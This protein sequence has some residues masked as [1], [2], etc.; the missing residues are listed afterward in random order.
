MLSNAHRAAV[1]AGIAGGLVSVIQATALGQGADGNQASAA[2]MRFPDISATQIVFVYANNL[3]I[4]PRDGGMAV[5]VATAPGAEGFPRFS[6]DGKTIA[7]MGNYDSNRDLYTIPTWGGTPSRVT[8][9]PAGE[10]L[11]D[12]TADGKLVFIG[13]GMAGL[14]RQTQIFTVPSEG[15]LP[16]KLPVPYAGFGTISPD[17]QWLCYA[18]HS[19][20]NRTWKRYRGGMATDLWVFN[21]RN[22]SAKKITDWEGTDT[23]PMWVPGGKSDVVYY[24]ADQGPEHRL[25]IWSYNVADGTRE[26]LTKYTSDDIRWPSIGPGADG[27]GEVIFQLGSELHVFDLGARQDRVVKITIPGDKPQVRTR[28]ADAARNISSAAISSSGKRV[29]IEARG[30]LWSAPAKEGIT[31]N[32]TNTNGV[33]ERDPSWSP[34]NK[35]IAYFS[36]E[37]GDYE[38]WIRGT[39]AKLPEEKK[40]EKK[41]AKKD[42]AKAEDAKKEEAAKEEAK[43]EEAKPVEKREPR[44]LTN[45]GPGFR[46]NPVWSPDSKHILFSD[47]S[48]TLHLIAV[49]SGELKKVDTDPWGNIPDVSWSQDN[50]WIAYTRSSAENPNSAIWV[51]NVKTGEKSQIVSGMFNNSAPAFDRAGDFM[52]FASQRT[53]NNPIYADSDTTFVYTG[54]GNIY[55]A[56]LRGDVKYPWLPKS[57]EEELKKEEKKDDAKKDGE[58]K[59]GE[60][61]DEAAKDEAKKD[62]AKKEEKKDAAADDGVSGTWEGRASGGQIPPDG[63]PFKLNLTLHDDGKVT[64]S[65]ASAMGSGAVTGTYNKDSGVITLSMAVGDD[66]VVTLT[67][68]LKNG[69]ITGSWNAGDQQGSWSARR[70]ASAS[71]GGGGGGGDSKSD[72]KKDEKKDEKKEV[73]IDAEGFESRAWQLPISPGAFG[74]L[75]VTDDNKLIYSRFGAR[76]Q[77]EPPSIKIFDPKDDAREEKTVTAGAGGFQL[78]ADGKK[79]LVMRGSQLTVM[80]AAAGGGTSTTVPTGDMQVSLKPREEWKQIV[81]D[82]WRLQRDFFY[83]PTMHG[84]DW[85]AARDHYLKMVD[86]AST[87]E[88]VNYIISEMISEL[89]IGHAY[90]GAPGDVESQPSAGTGVLG[91]DFELV[92]GPEGNAYKIAKIYEGGPWDAD[93]RNPLRQTGVDVKEGEFLLAVNGV[94]LDTA[95]DPWKI[96]QY[97]ADETVT[98][99]IGKTPSMA[100][101]TRDVM[102]KT[103]GGDGALRYRAWIERNRKY[104]EEKSGGKVGYIYVPNTGVDGQSDLFRQFFGQRH[105]PALI[106]DERWNGGGQIPTR[107]IELLNRPVVSYWARRHGQDWTWPPDA[108]N[109][110]KCMLIN[111]LAGSGGDMFPWLFKLNKIGKTIG[112]RTWGGLVGISGNPGLIDGGSITVPT[113]GIYETDGTWAV[114]GHGVDPDIEVLDDPSKMVDG[115]DPQLDTAITHM[116]DEIKNRPYTPAKRPVS[117][118]RKGMGIKDSDK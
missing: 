33:F 36:D 45:L 4:A 5:P 10:T 91:C 98:L 52:Y 105:L 41:D 56:P 38:L 65:V 31:R 57:D 83:E 70:S 67:G 53:I 115:G 17:G 6:P 13:N 46:Y 19:T 22:Q 117:P 76:G 79:L 15:G 32:L 50:N 54:T 27:K 18:P 62:D 114:E 77:Q 116:L 68:S 69:E 112:T 60:K 23:L 24:L 28:T 55:M 16:N 85:N 66:G 106:I 51:Y 99:T 48:G 89:N 97:R 29:V 3:W 96:F 42:D 39:D 8:H 90:L 30:D 44:K 81:N 37:S 118:D 80:S 71:G 88:D 25:N 72:D 75:V 78:S 35:W 47:N 107:F 113:F 59:D 43:A 95:V 101:D 86:D 58:K 49:E 40:D 34:D 61:K 11:C 108:H 104:V 2:M 92:K 73:K 111:G 1:I 109:G 110:P 102:V 14:A 20:D 7:F 63:I 93:A 100:K 82:A 103:L 74:Q 84:V 21:L 26:Q 12:W 9:H 64:G 94:P 87:R